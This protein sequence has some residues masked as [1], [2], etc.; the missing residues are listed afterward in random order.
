MELLATVAA[1][2]AAGD[3]AG[4]GVGGGKPEPAA[5]A[6]REA[7][8]S[9]RKTPATPFIS[10]RAETASTRGARGMPAAVHTRA[11]TGKRLG[12]T[13]PY[14]RG[15]ARME[16][17]QT[18]SGSTGGGEAVAAAAEVGKGAGGAPR[19]SASVHS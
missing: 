18:G 4:C 19:R 15:D 3:A 7:P 14:A 9:R 10:S 1:P 6:V 11:S 2:A 8:R 5:A 17:K 16:R 13:H 12:G